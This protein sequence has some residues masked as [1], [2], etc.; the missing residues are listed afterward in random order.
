[1]IEIF[2]RLSARAVR[3]N[4]LLISP[5]IKPA[6]RASHSRKALTRLERNSMAPA[7]SSKRWIGDA[8]R[9]PVPWYKPGLRNGSLW[10]SLL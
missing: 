2:S 9:D 10:A 1:M 6:A 7:N 4:R 5:D 3:S 8:I